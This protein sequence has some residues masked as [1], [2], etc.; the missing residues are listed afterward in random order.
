METKCKLLAYYLPAFHEVEENNN[1]YGK[2]FT[3][4]DNT[5][6]GKPFFIDHYQPRIPWKYY[7]LLDESVILEQMQMAKENGIDG[8]IYY[9]YWFDENGRKI[10]E[11][12]LENLITI[13]KDKRIDF[14]VCWANESWK[15][16]WHD[17]IGDPELL[18]EQKYGK[19]K[20][21]KNHFDYL[22]AFFKD[23]KYIKV[24]NC[25]MLI[26]Y[27]IENIPF[28]DEMFETWN[29]YAKE[30]GFNGVHIVRLY[31]S[32][33]VDGLNFECN[34][35]ADFE[36]GYTL[37]CDIKRNLFAK[38]RMKNWLYWKL[39]SNEWYSKHFLN[40][41]DYD[42]F[43]STLLSKTYSNPNKYCSII[44]DWDNSPRK[45]RRGTIFV[46]SSPSKFGKYLFNIKRFAE[47]NNIPYI[48]CFAWN[49]WGEG[50]YLEPD[51]KNGDAYLKAVRE[52]MLDGEIK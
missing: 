32:H 10:L 17:G 26:I 48:F 34:A 42:A 38:W 15:K 31:T 45:G 44:T 22:L 6:K 14:C 23:E 20:D 30:N 3:E 25:P 35:S 18:I 4:W 46:G 51:L 52:V 37:S 29:K 7:D 28:Y 12:P 19:E 2:G 1:W 33:K 13:E 8:F 24:N 41:V 9:H 47:K 5:K 43:Y 39:Y 50:G 16:T 27:K 40:K 11:K 36:P 49:E 21:W